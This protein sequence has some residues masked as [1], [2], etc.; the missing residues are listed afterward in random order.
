MRSK[1]IKEHLND[2]AYFEKMS[3]LLDE[4][5]AARKA[6]AVEYEDYLKRIAEIARKVESGQPDDTP[7][8]LNTPGKRALYNNLGNNEELALKIDAKVK[9]VRP[10]GWRGVQAKERVIQSALF[11]LL[12]DEAQVDKIFSILKAN[13]EY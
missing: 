6:K 8:N 2:P 1:I 3:S 9:A 13:Q 12:G 11:D 10:H 4:I 7:E 5:I